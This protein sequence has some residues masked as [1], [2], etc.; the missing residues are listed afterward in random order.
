M[1]IGFIE[2][3]RMGQKSRLG[4]EDVRHISTTPSGLYYATD[5]HIYKIQVDTSER[6][7]LI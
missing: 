6:K 7:K 4:P 2:S 1:T 3:E 5:K